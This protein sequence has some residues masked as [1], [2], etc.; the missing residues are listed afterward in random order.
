MKHPRPAFLF[1]RQTLQNRRRKGVGGWAFALGRQSGDGR[2]RLK[3][4]RLS[5]VR[6]KTDNGPLHFL[7]SFAEND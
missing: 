2:K 5:P 6:Q 1:S 3:W 4:A 7:K